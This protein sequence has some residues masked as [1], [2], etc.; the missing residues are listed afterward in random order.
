MAIWQSSTPRR[1]SIHRRR[2]KSFLDQS[3][4][5]TPKRHMAIEPCEERLLLAI[6]GPQLLAAIPATGTVIND[7]TVLKIAPTQ[8]LLRFDEAIDPNSLIINNVPTIL[9]GRSN[10]GTFGNADD[11]LITPGYIN[12]GDQPNEVIVRFNQD[13]PDDLY[14]MVIVG[15]GANPLRDTSG[16]AF[17]GGQNLIRPFELDLAPQVVGVVPQPVTRNPD[18]GKLQQDTNKIEVYFN[19]NDPLKLSSATDP[20]NYQLIRTGPVVPNSSTQ[21]TTTTADDTVVTLSDGVT[22]P[23]T[24]ITYDPTT[25]K[26]V[27][28]FAPG[29]LETA[30][31][32]RLRIGNSEPLPTGPQEFSIGNDVAGDTFDSAAP[33]GN[34]GNPFPLTLGTQTVVVNDEIKS[35]SLPLGTDSPYVLPGRRTRPAIAISRSNHTSSRASTMATSRSNRTTLTRSTAQ[36]AIRIST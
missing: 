30:G 23:I 15:D 5:M 32:Y 13:L 31:T 9:F 21:P 18:T 34:G 3:L 33:V 14:Q 4:R 6:D 17:N 28:T 10:D 8:I 7:N 29:I 16:L 12:I 27:L 26:A 36:G 20:D 35:V 1:K 2:R 22:S 24:N 11:V 19:V 25:G